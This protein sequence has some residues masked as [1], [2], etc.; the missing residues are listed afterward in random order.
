MKKL[1]QRIDWLNYKGK[2]MWE[3]VIIDIV[4]IVGGFMLVAITYYHLEV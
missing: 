4:L 3:E 1:L 2:I